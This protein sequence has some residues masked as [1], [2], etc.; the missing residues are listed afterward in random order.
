VNPY[1]PLKTRL[2]TERLRLAAEAIERVLADL[3][4][5]IR[6]GVTTGDLA[7]VA[8]L[9]FARHGLEG[10]LEGY[11]GFPAPMCTS[12]N[13]IAAHGVPGAQELAEGDLI[14]VDVS[15]HRAGAMADA[16]W[17]YGVGRIGAEQR[18]LLRAA[19]RSTLAGAAAARA[20]GRLGD[21][22]AAIVREARRAGC[23]VV[24]EFTGHGIGEEL[25]ESPVVPHVSEKGSGEP[26]VP[27]MVLNIEPVLTLGDGGVVRLDDGFSY[28]TSD[29][30][31]AAQ[32]EVT[33]A[34][35]SDRTDVL[36]LGRH[37][38]TLSASGPPY[39]V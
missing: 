6:P 16:A 8:R 5:V 17:T 3:A 11:E 30:T 32:F 19:W 29:G 31:L 20:G 25:H 7:Q 18:R 27:G 37:R 35:R 38:G 24:R 15:A 4:T 2:E 33:V 28:V 26:I 39:G 10:V 22:G 9:A 1:V 14:T 12:V 13:N 23:S 36:T 21:V 34:V